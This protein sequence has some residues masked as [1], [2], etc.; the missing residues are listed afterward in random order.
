MKV[1]RLLLCVLM[2]LMLTVTL[3]PMI[4]FAGDEEDPDD[5][6]G[7]QTIVPGDEPDEPR[8][9]F[10]RFDLGALMS[11]GGDPFSTD[12]HY[13]W[14]PENRECMVKFTP[15]EPGWYMLYSGHEYSGVNPE[16]CVYNYKGDEI[17]SDDNSSG[18]D[19]FKLVFEAT[20]D[21]TY[22]L[23]TSDLGKGTGYT[24]YLQPTTIRGLSFETKGIHTIY[25]FCINT[26]TNTYNPFWPSLDSYLY[27]PENDYAM[28]D[29]LILKDNEGSTTYTYKQINGSC[30]F[31][32][33]GDNPLNARPLL[34]CGPSSN[35]LKRECLGGSGGEISAEVMFMGLETNADFQVRYIYK[36]P[37]N[38]LEYHPAVAS[39][40]AK[41][42]TEEYWT[43]SA[44]EKLFSD[45]AG[46][47]EITQPVAVAKKPHDLVKTEA[48][49]AT[50]KAAGNK[51]YYTC[52]SCKKHFSDAKGTKVIA[53]NSW[54]INKL[55]PKA[56]KVK[57]MAQKKT[58]K[59]TVLKKKAVAVKPLTV[60]GA[61]GKVTYK[62][63][64]GNAKSK[65]ALK[66]NK[67]TG[68]V[69]VKKN[70][71]A[72]TY[73]VKVRVN[74]TASANKAFKAFKK[75]VAVVIVVK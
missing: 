71:K 14:S 73:T 41:A 51:E 67:K 48:K 74:S 4:A 26:N 75:T 31:Y 55:E 33:S 15:I 66:I 35:R 32:D 10:E 13:H 61:K 49:K 11:V 46:E 22:Y 9:P 43:C 23:Y 47:N 50:Y 16:A 7:G 59:A 56:Q 21:Q 8:S 5:S 44:C 27:S 72:G 58:A 34:D 64:G 1:K 25:D 68:K 53:A 70:T 69:T 39:T 42:G 2:S 19:N 57:V 17:A 29:K 62:I 65:K 52:K 30:Q 12:Q 37:D 6:T 60:K 24:V 63:V 20:K 38:A 45:A 28:G 36:H 18:N 3:I 54:I 40:C